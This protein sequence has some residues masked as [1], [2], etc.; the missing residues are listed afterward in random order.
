MATD[1][2]Q[3]KMND[4]LYEA[5]NE[6][7][8]MGHEAPRIFISTKG[9]GRL[10]FWW[11]YDAELRADEQIIGY[12]VL[13]WTCQKQEQEQEQEQEKEQEKIIYTYEDRFYR[14]WM[15][16]TKELSLNNIMEGSLKILSREY[17]SP[18]ARLRRIKHEIDSEKC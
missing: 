14:T 9:E 1:D 18:S 5:K 10:E 2:K 12:L 15:F 17:E 16:G 6:L 4:L 3:K 13:S 8:R 11:P 7:M